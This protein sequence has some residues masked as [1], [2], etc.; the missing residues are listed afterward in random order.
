MNGAL[1]VILS[2]L[3]PQ[4]T[5]FYN[6]YQ[7]KLI[8]ISH[9]ATINKIFVKKSCIELLKIF[10]YASIITVLNEYNVQGR[11]KIVSLLNY[12]KF[13]KN[14]DFEKATECLNSYLSLIPSS[15]HNK[16]EVLKINTLLLPIELIKELFWNIEICYKIQNYL[17]LLAL[18]FRLEEA[19]LFE[20]NNYLFKDFFSNEKVK[21]DLNNKEIHVDFINY[22]SNFETDLWNNLQDIK[23]KGQLIDIKKNILD[24]P[25]LFYIAKLKIKQ[26]KQLEGKYFYQIGNMLEIFD[27]INKYCYSH[28]DNE[29]RKKRYKQVKSTE[30]LGDLR[31]SSI[32]AHGFEPVSKEKIEYLYKENIDDFVI[33]LKKKLIDLLKFLVKDDYFTIDNIFDKINLKLQILIKK[34]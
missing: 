31:N 17:L 19:I 23:F 9:E 7:E 13:R 34:L 1:Y 2:S 33:D 32:S 20:I 22:L 14:F 30:C 6:V 8:P 16:Y 10:E 27:K 11:E 4:D 15:E 5:E 3:F 21:G 24:R 18:L 25:L 29:E 12:A 28:L 26:V